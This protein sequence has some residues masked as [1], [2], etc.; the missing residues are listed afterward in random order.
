MAGA[1]TFAKYDDLNSSVIISFV[2]NKA[3]ERISIDILSGLSEAIVNVIATQTDSLIDYK[4][5]L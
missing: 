4:K 5:A 3:C 2:S 1:L